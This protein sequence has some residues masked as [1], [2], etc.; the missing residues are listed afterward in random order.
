MRDEND[1]AIEQFRSTANY[2]GHSGDGKDTGR[3]TY[4]SKSSFHASEQ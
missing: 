3:M 2:V 4:V 1:D